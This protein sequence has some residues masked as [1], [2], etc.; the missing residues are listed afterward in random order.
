MDEVYEGIAIKGATKEQLIGVIRLQARKVTDLANKC[1]ELRGRGGA[2]EPVVPYRENTAKLEEEHRKEIEDLREQKRLQHECAEDLE[3]R[4]RG[5]G[6]E[7]RIILR[8]L[9]R[10]MG[11][12][13][14]RD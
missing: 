12:E 8:A 9:D 5:C 14:G 6:R 2:G 7:R 4:L 13:D 3:F 1:S 10:V 11:M